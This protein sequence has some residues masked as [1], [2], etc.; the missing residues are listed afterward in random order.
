MRKFSKL[1]LI[2][3]ITTGFVAC[4]NDIPDNGET[5]G[6]TN[7]S[8]VVAVS[9]N[10]ESLPVPKSATRAVT[11][12]NA[13]DA[14]IFVKDVL[15][16]GEP[17]E[18]QIK[19]FAMA[20]DQSQET[21]NTIV[22]N[23]GAW[24]TAKGSRSL[25]LV[26]NAKNEA[27]FNS[28]T[29]ASLNKSAADTDAAKA[30][31]IFQLVRTTTPGDVKTVE[32]LVMS[33]SNNSRSVTIEDGVSASDANAST[34]DGVKN[35][36]DF[37]IVRTVAKARMYS[38][39]GELETT[40][41]FK[42]TVKNLAFSVINGRTTTYITPR[43]TP[44]SPDLSA[45]N[46]KNF[47]RLGNDAANTVKGEGTSLY[48]PIDVNIADDNKTVKHGIYFMENIVPGTDDP[49]KKYVWGNTA[50]AKVYVTFV[51]GSISALDAD[52]NVVTKTG[53]AVASVYT[54]GEDFYKGVVT[55]KL[56]NSTAAAVKDGN[57][58][59]WTYKGGKCIYRVFLNEAPGEGKTHDT[60]RNHIYDLTI[61]SVSGLGD[62][63]DVVDPNDPNLPKPKNPEEPTTPPSGGDEKTPVN[64]TNTHMRVVA[65]IAKWEVVERDVDLGSNN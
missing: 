30:T 49:D 4:N 38:S 64:T 28:F 11:D 3:A 17:A 57:S 24:P 16:Y 13:T 35:R 29:S 20:R 45:D 23:T 42:A 61:T 26:L 8:I 46:N 19:A 21:G 55:G 65:K 12:E 54:E 62:N 36:F 60:Q 53:D 51:P 48:R 27:P 52:N 33:A 41:A 56:Y 22:Y 15:L 18:G 63:Y 47:V 37:P 25:A 59:Y 34:A 39:K 5:P 10:T 40:D 50:Y 1:L 2:A 6:Q 31:E 58:T 14:E 32:S 7:A 9:K 43:A 44:A